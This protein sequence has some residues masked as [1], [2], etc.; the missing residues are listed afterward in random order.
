MEKLHVVGLQERE[1]VFDNLSKRD[2]SHVGKLLSGVMCGHI[3]D[4]ELQK[5]DGIVVTLDE[6]LQWSVWPQFL[7]IC[8]KCFEFV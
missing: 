3:K 6:L 8:R 1:G 7:K 2:L 4:A 5:D